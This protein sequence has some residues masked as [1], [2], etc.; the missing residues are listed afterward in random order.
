MPWM[1]INPVQSGQLFRSSWGNAVR[2]NLYWLKDNMP[3]DIVKDILISE[4]ADSVILENLDINSDKFY[5][6]HCCGTCA[7]SENDG[8]LAI[9]FNEDYNDRNYYIQFVSSYGT[10]TTSR[11]YR[12]AMVSDTI[13][14]TQPFLLNA[15]IARTSEGTIYVS[16][17]YVENQ[18]DTAKLKHFVINRY[19]TS[20]NLNTIT[21]DGY[22]TLVW[23]T[24]SRIILQKVI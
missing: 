9:Y 15:I 14:Y 8:L 7:D 16:G 23:G 6:L 5:F 11:R 13:Y 3:S 20:N 12:S 19:V 24:G 1:D 22:G 4:P 10:T 21:L 2:N 18:R 17:T